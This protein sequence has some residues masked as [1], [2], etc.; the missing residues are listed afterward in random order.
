LVSAGV[1]KKAAKLPVMDNAFVSEQSSKMTKHK[2]YLIPYQESMVPINQ[3]S[4]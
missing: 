2:N 3:S 4:I 1:S